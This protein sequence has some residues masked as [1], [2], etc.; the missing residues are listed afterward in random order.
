MLTYG[1]SHLAGPGPINPAQALQQTEDF[2][3]EWCSRCTYQGDSRGLVMRS[4]ITLK[5][6][7]YAPDRRQRRGADD[8]AAGASWAGCATGTTGYCWLRDAA[9][10]VELALLLQRLH[11]KRRSRWREWL[12]RAAAGVAGGSC[13]Y[14]YGVTGERRLLDSGQAGWLP[15]YR[16]RSVPVRDRQRRRRPSCSWTSTAS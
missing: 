6:L 14:M 12:R 13:R 5:A 1:P 7:T 8:L 3:T 2:W 11:A 16:R 10:H 15:G 4:L 9:F